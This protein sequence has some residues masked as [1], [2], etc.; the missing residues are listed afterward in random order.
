MSSQFRFR[1]LKR[2]DCKKMAA[3]RLEG[4]EWGF[5]PALGEAFYTEILKGT[6][7]SKYGFGIICEDKNKNLAGFVCAATDLKKYYTD[8]LLRRGIFLS[9][10]ALPRIIRQ[11]KLIFGIFPY[12]FYSKR[13]PFA[14]IKAEWLTM[15]VRS[16]YRGMGVGKELTSSLTNEFKARN[17]S[18][19]KSTVSACNLISCSLHEQYGFKLLG[20]Y[21][22]AGEMI[23]IYSYEV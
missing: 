1:P 7:D 9:F 8:I 12:L 16:K 10:F 21:N 18:Q 11:P 2:T 23:N 19:Y 5:L 14:D 22:L 20:T 17:I 4:K 3:V 15:I 13:V 6:C